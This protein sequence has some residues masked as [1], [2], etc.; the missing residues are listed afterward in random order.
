MN[1]EE[2]PFLTVEEKRAYLAEV[3][4]NKKF[5]YSEADRFK[6][7]KEDTRLCAILLEP[8]QAT[9]PSDPPEIDGSFID[10]ALLP[11]ALEEATAQ[12]W[13]I[14]KIH[15]AS[16]RHFYVVKQRPKK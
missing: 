11:A 5:F 14:V 9:E 12:G 2:S 4:R 6:A 8:K 15:T 7:L 1:N 3:F 16:D 13:H 10:T